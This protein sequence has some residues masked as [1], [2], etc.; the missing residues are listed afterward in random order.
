MTRP[1]VPQDL[2]LDNSAASMLGDPTDALRNVFSGALNALMQ[3]EVAALINASA[4]ERSDGRQDYRNGT[5]PRR[6]DTRMGTLDLEIPR[7]RDSSYTPSFLTNYERCEAAL[8]SLVQEAYISGV[9]TRKIQKLVDALGIR[10][11]SK[12]HSTRSLTNW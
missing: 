12:S 9:S 11:L 1:I 6:L 8:V 10:S 7:T 4:Y 5:R 2:A 3:Q